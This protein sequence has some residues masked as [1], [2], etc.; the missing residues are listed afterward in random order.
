M[1]KERTIKEAIIRKYPSIGYQDSL[2]IAIQKMAEY[3]ASALVVLSKDILVGLVTVTDI[4]QCLA[5]EQDP[6]ETLVSSFMTQCEL[7]S[8]QGTVN[9]CAQL[10][11][12]QDPVSAIKVLH[13]AG[14]NHLVVSRSDGEPVGVVS[15]LELIKLFAEM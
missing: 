2:T 12:E 14:V 7:I 3:N 13:A 4:I 5:Q 11:E 1:L 8:E 9:P 15:S 6:E 10:D